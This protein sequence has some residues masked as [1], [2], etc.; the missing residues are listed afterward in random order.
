MQETWN[1]LI[2]AGLASEQRDPVF[3]ESCFRKALQSSEL[4]FGPESPEAGLCLIELADFLERR[5]QMDESARL[6]DRYR[7]ILV[8][9]A[10]RLGIDKIRFA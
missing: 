1:L 3:S 9:Y 2:Q 6:S 8:N 4:H 7:S 10:F 5:G